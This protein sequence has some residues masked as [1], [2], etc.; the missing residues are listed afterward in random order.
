MSANPFSVAVAGHPPYGEVARALA[1]TGRFAPGPIGGLV[2]TLHQGVWLESDEDAPGLHAGGWT[3]DV[4]P[5]R[6]QEI[7]RRVAHD[8]AALLLAAGIE[9]YVFHDDP[10]IPDPSPAGR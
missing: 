8:A 6:Q 5:E 9:A 4:L 1:A 2:D 10:A 7:T 3:I